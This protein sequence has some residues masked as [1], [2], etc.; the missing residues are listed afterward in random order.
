MSSFPRD[1]RSRSRASNETIPHFNIQLESIRDRAYPFVTVV[2]TCL[3][4]PPKSDAGHVAR[5]VPAGSSRCRIGTDAYETKDVP[6]YKAIALLSRLI[7]SRHRGAGPDWWE[8]F[9]SFGDD[10][11]AD[12]AGADGC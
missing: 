8:Y 3:V 7:G 5:P 11:F 6:L 4:A 1:S 12:E 10:F 9:G 2:R